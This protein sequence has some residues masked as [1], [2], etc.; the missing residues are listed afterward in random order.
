MVTFYKLL[1]ISAMAH[2]KF[3][4]SIGGDF[5]GTYEVGETTYPPEFAPVAW[6][7]D[8]NDK[9]PVALLATMLPL[10]D[11]PSRYINSKSSIP[12]GGWLQ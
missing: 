10:Q 3:L 6:L 1:L 2:S 11:S 5:I 4:K 12:R 8:L 7:F 9:Y